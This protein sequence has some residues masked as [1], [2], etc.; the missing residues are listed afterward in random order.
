M[1]LQM[2]LRMARW[3]G[4]GGDHNIPTFSPKSTGII[5]G[6]SQEYPCIT[7]HSIYAPKQ[8]TAAHDFSNIRNCIESHIPL[9]KKSQTLI[10]SVSSS[11]IKSCL[12]S[13]PHTV[14]QMLDLVLGNSLSFQGKCLNQLLTIMDMLSACY[15]LTGPIDAQWGSNQE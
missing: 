7:Y 11:N 15:A 1:T 3:M 9:N 2:D 13:M 10:S 12:T 14:N 4:E 5:I 8:S 6:P